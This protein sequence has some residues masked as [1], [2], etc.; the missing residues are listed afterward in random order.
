MTWGWTASEAPASSAL[1]GP[2]TLAW[3][4]Y[5]NDLPHQTKDG[6]SGGT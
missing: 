2:L 4:P 5:A 6:A 3:L 1:P